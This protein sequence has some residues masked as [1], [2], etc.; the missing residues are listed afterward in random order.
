MPRMSRPPESWSIVAVF[1][2]SRIGCSTVAKYTPVPNRIVP[3]WGMSR[4][5]V[6]SGWSVT[7]EDR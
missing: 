3:E 1:S 5:R 7:F 2:A 4:A 6:G